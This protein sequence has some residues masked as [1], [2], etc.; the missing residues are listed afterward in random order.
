MSL[1]FC[2]NFSNNSKVIV[3][4]I[5]IGFGFPHSNPRILWMNRP[6]GLFSSPGDKVSQILWRSQ[7]SQQHVPSETERYSTSTLLRRLFLPI[8]II[9]STWLAGFSN[10]LGNGINVIF[11]WQKFQFLFPDRMLCSALAIQSEKLKKNNKFLF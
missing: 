7:V 11:P 4:Y 10:I 8:I 5:W 2:R 3:K 1:L 9:F 6:E